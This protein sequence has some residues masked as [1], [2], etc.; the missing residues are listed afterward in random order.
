M[1]PTTICNNNNLCEYGETESN[2]PQDCFITDPVITSTEITPNAIDTKLYKAKII[3]VDITSAIDQD[4][5]I[6]VEGVPEN[7]IT[8]EE[9]V[10]VE[11]VDGIYHDSTYIYIYPQNLGNYNVEIGVHATGENKDFSKVIPLFVAKDAAIEE[12]PEPENPSLVGDIIS[13]DAQN[14]VVFNPLYFFLIIFTIALVIIVI[15]AL[16]LRQ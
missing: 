10:D 2:C 5:T 8:F 15:A 6:S 7:W 13:F 4:F 3:S 1:A 14:S 9:R 16:R 11:I 12:E